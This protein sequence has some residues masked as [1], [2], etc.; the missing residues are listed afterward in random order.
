[1]GDRRKSIRKLMNPPKGKS[2]LSFSTVRKPVRSRAALSVGCNVEFYSAAPVLSRI[3]S[4][5][6]KV[7]GP[8]VQ[9]TSEMRNGRRARS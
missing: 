9:G 3:F 4:L 6:N 7:N 8:R 2:D 5:E 1:M